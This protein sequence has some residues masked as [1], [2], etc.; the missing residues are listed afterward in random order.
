M[1]SMIGATFVTWSRPM[2][3]STSSCNSEDRSF[4]KR[5]DMQPATMSFCS[6][7]RFF[8]P[9][10]WWTS[11]MWPI[12]SSLE[13]SMKEPVLTMTTSAFSA[14]GMTTMPAW[15]KWPT[16]ISLSTRFLAQP[17]EM[18]LTLIMGYKKQRRAGKGA[19]F[20]RGN[21][22]GGL[23]LGLA[24]SGLEAGIAALVVSDAAFLFDVLV[25]L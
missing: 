15:C 9:L 6:L 17:R 10:F 2:K 13:E 22:P 11:R 5:C 19:R 1:A 3:A 24:D 4:E 14:S 20:G 12:D 16:M 18:R 8:I 25:E 23:L 21:G 7:R